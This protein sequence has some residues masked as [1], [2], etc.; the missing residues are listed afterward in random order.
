MIRSMTGYGRCEQAYEDKT[1]QVEIRSVNHR[2]FE[3]S[4]RIPRVYAFLEDKIKA[5]VQ[6]RVFRGKVD[7]F[8]TINTISTPGTVVQVNQD[9]AAGYLAAMQEL[10]KEFGLK[11]EVPLGLITRFPDVL[12]VIKAPEDEERILADFMPVLE[13]AVD[14]FLS[15]REYEGERLREDVLEKAGNILCLVEQVENGSAVMV[16][17]Y[18]D[19]LKARL[20]EILGDT[21]VDEQRIVTE[22]AIF[23]DKTAVAEEIVRL[24]S[25]VSQLC[26]L[27]RSDGAVGRKLDFLVQEM[28]REANT[29]GSKSQNLKITRTVV[30][31]KSEIEKIRE[32]I[33][34][35]E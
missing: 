8:V 27:V 14:A 30:D 15:M 29:I 5:Y 22:A 16:K 7:V 24:R 21:N 2:F 33:Q 18:H 10:S 6:S 28:N 19:R 31:I 17:E 34:N 20:M 4:S 32:Q 9:L 35:I 11:N 26:E 12:T 25:H 1:I 23:A 3:F 13:K